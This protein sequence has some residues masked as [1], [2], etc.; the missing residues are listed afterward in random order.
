MSKKLKTPYYNNK[1][2]LKAILVWV[3]ILLISKKNYCKTEFV[4]FFEFKRKNILIF[5]IHDHIYLLEF[6]F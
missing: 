2:R 5:L 3:K 6:K 4:W 1:K